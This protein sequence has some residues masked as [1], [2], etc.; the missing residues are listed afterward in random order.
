M[1]E[2]CPTCARVDC[3]SL[4]T[5]VWLERVLKA[6]MNVFTDAASTRDKNARERHYEAN[7]ACREWVK[8]N[9]VVSA[10][11]PPLDP[12]APPTQAGMLWAPSDATEADLARRQR[13]FDA[14]SHKPRGRPRRGR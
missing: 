7:Y 5:R 13:V 11:A 9:P 2:R 4:A 12:D 3:P 10:A 8:A 14:M 6:D 1:S